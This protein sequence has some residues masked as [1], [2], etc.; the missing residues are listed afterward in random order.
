MGY[1]EIMKVIIILF[2]FIHI[3]NE[4]ICIILFFYLL[5]IV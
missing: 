4:K 1:N 5:S 3:K 2:I